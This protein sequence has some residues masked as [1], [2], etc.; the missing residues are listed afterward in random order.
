MFYVLEHCPISILQAHGGGAIPRLAYQKANVLWGHYGS[1][2]PWNYRTVP[3]TPCTLAEKKNAR[4]NAPRHTALKKKSTRGLR[5]RRCGW[6]D[7]EGP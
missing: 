7:F 6:R 1:T 2:E 3:P 4:K 5:H